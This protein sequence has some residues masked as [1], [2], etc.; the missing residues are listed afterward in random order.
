MLLNPAPSKVAKI[1]RNNVPTLGRHGR[2]Q[3]HVIFR[4]FEPG[5]PQK[6]DAL[7]MGNTAQVAQELENVVSGTGA[8]YVLGPGEHVLILQI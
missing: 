6:E 1:M 3:H 5:A 2:F 8:S 7:S 4:I